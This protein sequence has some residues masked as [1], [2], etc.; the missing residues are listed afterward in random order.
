VVTFPQKTARPR[1]GALPR[2]LRHT[3]DGSSILRASD[4]GLVRDTNNHPPRK[5]LVP[6]PGACVAELE[7]VAAEKSRA[8]RSSGSIHR[9]S[10][11]G[12]APEAPASEAA[13]ARMA[14][15]RRRI[16]AR[17]Y[18]AARLGRG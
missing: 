15:D 5:I 11:R 10:G 2:P 1:I 18:H 8:A 6:A 3:V 16:R 9:S 13:V 12:A 4:S 14:Q 17:M 7:E